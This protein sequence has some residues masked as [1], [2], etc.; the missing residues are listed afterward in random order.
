[1]CI[2]PVL[3][4]GFSILVRHGDEGV[5]SQVKLIRVVGIT[6]DVKGEMVSLRQLF[7][8]IVPKV[9]PNSELHYDF[10]S[11]ILANIVTFEF[12]SNYGGQ[13]QGN[14]K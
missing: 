9:R 12:L 3:L 10:N 11:P 5:A 14:C 2:E 1:M 7:K 13:E 4:S 8:V 6:T